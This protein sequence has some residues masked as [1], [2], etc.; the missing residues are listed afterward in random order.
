MLLIFQFTTYTRLMTLRIEKKSL[1]HQVSLEAPLQKMGVVEVDLSQLQK[2]FCCIPRQN[3]STI[4]GNHCL[5]SQHTKNKKSTTISCSL[6]SAKKKV[7][8]ARAFV[9]EQE[10]NTKFLG[11][12]KQLLLHPL[13]SKEQLL[14]N[15]MCEPFLFLSSMS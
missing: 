7:F 4:Q 8:L 3:K 15:L 5:I 1:S 14:E 2:V 12:G 9:S 13:S 11:V 6:S 10:C